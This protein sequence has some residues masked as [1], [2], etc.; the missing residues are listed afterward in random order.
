[1]RKQ[2]ITII[3]L[4]A[5]AVTFSQVGI[6]TGAPKA[7]LDV[8]GKPTEPTTLD[9]IIAPR[10][11]GD[12]LRAKLYTTDQ[13]GAFVYVTAADTAPAEQTA[14]VT[15]IGYYYFDGTKWVTAGAG[16]MVNIYNSDGSLTDDRTVNMDG[17]SLLF[18]TAQRSIYFDSEGRI[19]TI[20]NGSYDADIYL[21][22]GSGSTYSRFDIQSWPD[23]QAILTATGA[24]NRGILITS[25]WTENSAPVQI[26]AAP[27]GGIGANPVA[28]FSGERDGQMGVGS[29]GTDDITEKLTVD[30]TARLSSLPLNGAT[31]VIYTQPDGNASSSQNQTFTATRTVVADENGVLGYSAG[32]PSNDINIYKDNGTL[33]ANRVVSQNNYSLTVEGSSQRTIFRNNAGTGITQDSGSGTRASIGLSNGGVPSLWL[34]TDTNSTAQINASGNS[35]SLSIGTNTANPAPLNFKTSNGS[36]EIGVQRAQIAADGRFNVNNM[37]SI[38]YT[39]QQSFLGTERLK[40]NGS[41]VT[42]GATYPDYVFQDYFDGS[43]K[44]NSDYKFTTIYEAEKFIKENNHLPGVTPIGALEKT[45]NGYA[46]NLT[47]LSVQLLEKIEELYLYTIEQQK[48]IDELTNLV[49]EL[50]K[51]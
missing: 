42:A 28:I 16:D 13:T 2:F 1:M 25:N 30:G 12:Q 50:Q 44:L 33:T 17:K 38:G 18:G 20:S 5:S 46:I 31:N 21:T 47:D 19:G 39:G 7:T 37:L 14:D 36:G 43:S 11:T 23:G 41:I 49:K 15:S 51:R 29:L 6:D 22:T 27:G 3:A 26:S 9:G 8:V 32:L 24:G 34:F 35:T 40:V 10:L 4:V 45:E 48:Q